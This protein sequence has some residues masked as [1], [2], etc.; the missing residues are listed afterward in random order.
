MFG[1]FTE[2]HTIQGVSG[3]DATGFFEMVKSTVVR[4]LRE[5]YNIKFRIVLV[6]L[7]EKPNPS[8]KK[9]EVKG[10]ILL[11][12]SKKPVASTPDTP[13]MVCLSVKFQNADSDEL[14]SNS[15]GSVLSE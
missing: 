4:K 3:V 9:P 12:I 7:L 1:N 5:K 8:G 15:L 6:C 14:I 2:R 11:T 10:G 13:C